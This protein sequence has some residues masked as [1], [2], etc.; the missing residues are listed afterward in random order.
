MNGLEQYNSF[1]SEIIQTISS[2]RYEAYKLLNKHHIGLNF[3]IGKLIVKNQEVNDWGKSIVDTL[4][5]DI[6]KQIDGIKGYSPQNLWRMRQFYLEYKDE[7]ELLE[8]ATKIP[9]GQN[10]LIMHQIKDSEER[11]YYLTATDKLAWSRSVLLN[12]IK[13]NAYQNHLANPKQHNFE[14]TL[15]VHLSEQANEALKSEYNLDFL[16]INKPVLERELENRLIENI[17][18]L[19]L[20]LGY[21]FSFIGN[22]YRLKLNQKEYFIDLLFYHRF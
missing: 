14:N 17:R 15:P 21:G 1:F 9:W 18:D 22:Q 6:N 11:K 13:A 8:L 5:L 7:Q 20:E 10:L 3:E 16:G 12:Q 4:S 19:L 2:A